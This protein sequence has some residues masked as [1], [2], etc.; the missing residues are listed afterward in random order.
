MDDALVVP[1]PIP[2]FAFAGFSNSG[3]TTLVCKVIANLKERGLRIAS[4]KH[5]GHDFSM[6]Q[7]GKDTWQ[8]QQAGAEVVAIT[9]AN[10][11]AILDYR[12][13][14]REEQLKQVLQYIRDVDLIIVEGF[15][16]VPIPKIFIVRDPSHIKHIEELPAIEGIAT[17]LPR[18]FFVEQTGLP[19]YDINDVQSLCNY[20]VNRFS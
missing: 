10:K 8:H 9:S 15:K 20:I 11:L 17:D 1:N 3:K 4:V 5:D 14:E 7:Q 2:V 6:D 19:V 12:S 13:Y 16:T 18:D